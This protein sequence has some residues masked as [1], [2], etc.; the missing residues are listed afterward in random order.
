[1]YFDK[2]F[3]FY[4]DHD[5][6]HITKKE[7]MDSIINLGLRPRCEERCRS[8][9]DSRKAIY[10][11]DYLE[12]ADEWAQEL[13]NCKNIEELEILKFNLKRRVWHSSN[14]SI[15]DFY[16]TNM[17]KSKDLF[18]LSEISKNNLL[19]KSYHGYNNINIWLP[20]SDYHQEKQKVINLY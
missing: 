1:M 8:I 13:F 14:S 3:I 6:F 5:A 2:D 20:I 18:Y 16:L 4:C 11:F 10:F 17:V 12:S 7:N 15:G 19:D 9:G